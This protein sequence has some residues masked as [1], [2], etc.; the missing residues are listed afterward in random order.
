MPALAHHAPRQY[1]GRIAD[2]AQPKQPEHP[3]YRFPEELTDEQLAELDRADFGAELWVYCRFDAL[4][5]TILAV[6]D[7]EPVRVDE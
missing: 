1:T 6:T 5:V 3:Q 4:E 2:P 7:R